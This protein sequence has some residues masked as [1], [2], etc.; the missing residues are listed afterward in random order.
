[1]EVTDGN[2]E[3]LAAGIALAATM[4]S[5]FCAHDPSHVGTNMAHRVLNSS[6]QENGH[7]TEQK[8]A[9]PRG[10]IELIGLTWVCR[11]LNCCCDS[12]SSYSYNILF[13]SRPR[14]PVKHT[15]LCK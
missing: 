2:D 9:G 12:Q 4:Q 3:A 14:F 8:R 10:E 5:F 15:V 13:R 11:Q 7:L 1:M 6:T